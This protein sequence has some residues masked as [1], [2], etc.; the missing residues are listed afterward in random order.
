M[1]QQIMW[2][3]FEGIFRGQASDGTVITIEDEALKMALNKA[4]NDVFESDWWAETLVRVLEHWGIYGKRW[5]D[6]TTH[7]G[8]LHFTLGEPKAGTGQ[9]GP[10]TERLLSGPL[11][12][13]MLPK[14]PKK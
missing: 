13:R 9:S 4:G 2:N 6:D 11:S 10:L 14:E 3:Q 7:T 12:T 1:A 5:S 8:R